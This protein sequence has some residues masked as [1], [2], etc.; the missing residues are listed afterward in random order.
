MASI[1]I[2][3]AKRALDHEVPL[4]PFIDLLLCCVMFLLV[5][6]VWNRLAALDGVVSRPSIDGPM[7]APP[8]GPRLFVHVSA[9]SFLVASDAG[10]RVV[11]PFA[12]DEPDLAALGAHLSPRRAALGSAPSA[13]DIVVV[14]DDGVPYERVIAT[15]DTIT[16]AG[17]DR[18]SLGE[19]L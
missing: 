10:D 14:A 12:D 7:I 15:M 2:G 8:P 13:G 6:A 1:Q 3:S 4:I 5:T 18:V 16:A 11:I 19:G 9:R 17:F